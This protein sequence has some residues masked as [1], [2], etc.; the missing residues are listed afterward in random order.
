MNIKSL[1]PSSFGLSLCIF[2]MSSAFQLILNFMGIEGAAAISSATASFTGAMAFTYYFYPHLMSRMFKIY[3]ILNLFAITIVALIFTLFAMGTFGIVSAYL[4]EIISD[5]K[6]LIAFVGGT[7]LS[8]AFQGLLFYLG[9]HF[10]NKEGLKM[11]MAK[12]QK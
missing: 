10:G 8:F 5:A 9:I 7:L 12:K 2:L 3:A 4:A 11:V 6:I 1:I